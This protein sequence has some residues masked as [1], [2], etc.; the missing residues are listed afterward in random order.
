MESF[1]SWT[2]NATGLPRRHDVA[3]QPEKSYGEKTPDVGGISFARFKEPGVRVLHFA[4]FEQVVR[5]RTCQHSQQ[6]SKAAGTLQR[7]LELQE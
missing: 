4:T 1:H 7:G 3:N 5:T 2:F 6:A